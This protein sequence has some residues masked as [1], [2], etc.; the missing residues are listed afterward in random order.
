MNLFIY[1]CIKTQLCF[2]KKKKKKKKLTE[3][4]V[5]NEN[6]ESIRRALYKLQIQQTNV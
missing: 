6:N 3:S 2:Q 5:V 1:R 4:K